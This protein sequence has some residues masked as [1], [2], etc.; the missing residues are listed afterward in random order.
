V[1]D[2]LA[3]HPALTLRHVECYAEGVEP[4]LLRVLRSARGGV[5]VL[6]LSR[7]GAAGAA[8]LAGVPPPRALAAAMARRNTLRRL[9]LDDGTFTTAE[10][11]ELVRELRA[12]RAAPPAADDDG[13]DAPPTPPQAAAPLFGVPPAEAA[14]DAA[15]AAEEAAAAACPLEI[16]LHGHVPIAALWTLAQ[17]LEPRGQHGSSLDAMGTTASGDVDVLVLAKNAHARGVD[18]ALLGALRSRRLALRRLGLYGLPRSEHALADGDDVA[19]DDRHNGGGDA[20]ANADADADARAHPQVAALAAALRSWTLPAPA[21][22]AFVAAAAGAGAGAARPFTLPLAPGVSSLT[23]L[24]FADNGLSGADVAALL[25]AARAACPALESLCVSGNA[26]GAA[27]AA[28][29]LGALIA[30][31]AALRE[32]SADGCGL[33]DR[34][35]AAL[36]SGLA[37]GA[38]PGGANAVTAL[39]LARNGIGDAGACRLAAALR[40]RHPPAVRPRE[41]ASLSRL[42]PFSRSPRLITHSRLLSAPRAARGAGPVRQRHPL[43]R[44][45]RARRRAVRIVVVIVIVAVCA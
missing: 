8:A 34:G 9:E 23:Q 18:A 14:A 28:A 44:R 22:P 12:A 11:A 43:R 39:H 6:L 33:G 17:A 37:R 42:F 16:T 19:C 4:R 31:A 29:A 7:W 40:A 13:D 27:P 41:T 36:A 25:R 32:V 15:E 1:H 24:S 5:R 21:P 20:G 30:H 2:A 10:I 38:A 45:R 26:C 3:A 35:A